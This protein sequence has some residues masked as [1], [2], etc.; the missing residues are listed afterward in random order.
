MAVDPVCGIH[1]DERA[2]QP[3]EEFTSDYNGK[4]FY[5]CS[6]ECKQAFEE[7]PGQYGEKTA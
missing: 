6:E 1:V 3:A 2:A 4:T 5:F 7:A